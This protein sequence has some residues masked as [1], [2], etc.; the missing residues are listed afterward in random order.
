M[1][2]RHLGC[3]EDTAAHILQTLVNEGK[4]RCTSLHGK[5]GFWRATSRPEGGLKQRREHKGRKNSLDPNRPV[6]D[7]THV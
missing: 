3:R 5:G 2:A 4:V 6:I 7:S 1:V